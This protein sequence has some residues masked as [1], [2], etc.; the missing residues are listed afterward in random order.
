MTAAAELAG[1]LV[2]RAGIAAR[3]LIALAGPPGAGKSTLASSLHQELI[4]RGESAVVVPMDG[5]H[6]DDGIL[7]ARGDRTRKGAPHTFDIAGFAALLRRIKSCEPD[8]AIPVFDRK[9]ELSRAAAAIVSAADKFVIVE[10]NYLLL[11]VAPWNMLRLLFDVTIM[12][13]VPEPELKRRLRERIL[14]HGH[15]EAF[16]RHWI[17]TNDMPNARMVTAGSMPADIT[18]EG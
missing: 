16:A 11:Q 5:F 13:Q 15:D 12:L 8:V 3:V 4:R 1:E 2:E 17:E 10:G 9:L 18:V 14:R 6:F 7:E